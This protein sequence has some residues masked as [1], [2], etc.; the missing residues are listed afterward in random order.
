MFIQAPQGAGAL[1]RLQRGVTLAVL[2][3]VLCL[4]VQLTV[5]GFVH[6]TSVRWETPAETSVAQP[7]PMVVTSSPTATH[8]DGG[9]SWSGRPIA[10]KTEP[11]RV[12]GWWDRVMNQYST[13][14]A[15][16]GIV[17]ML[18]LVVQLSIG[19][20]VATVAGVARLDLMVGALNWGLVLALLSLPLQQVFPSLP[21]TGT[22]CAY[23]TI[24]AANDGLRGGT[25]RA[26]LLTNHA[27]I[28]MASVLIS[29]AV[30]WW[31]RQG[32]AS[33]GML[34]RAQESERQLD[35][36]MSV[37]QERGVGSNYGARTSATM[38]R[39]QAA[40]SAAPAAGPLAAPA[41]STG[42]ARPQPAASVV[43]KILGQADAEA[44]RPL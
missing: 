12:L 33:M 4:F 28:P 17:A 5:F 37:Y 40:P 10:V 18:Y 13:A 25:S 23:D 8:P 34:R 32:V 42:R 21:F 7:A 19:V 29:L 24:T 22:F 20:V 30:L 9:S 11:V 35:R 39:W 36:E 6:F 1:L 38:D 14:A 15:W 43:D 41:P 31:F 16:L 27:A 3:S 44:K 26:L 2:L